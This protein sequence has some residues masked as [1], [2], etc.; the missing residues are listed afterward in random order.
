M[1]PFQFSVQGT[2]I[3]VV[4]G[5][6][7]SFSLFV[8]LPNLVHLATKPRLSGYQTVKRGSQRPVSKIL[9]FRAFRSV[10]Y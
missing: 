3:G 2:D 9:D 1:Y 5:A 4:M 8:W 6:M 10:V 7:A